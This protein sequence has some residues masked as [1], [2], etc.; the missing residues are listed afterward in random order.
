MT[1]GGTGTRF[2]L[3]HDMIARQVFAKASAEAQTRRKIERYVR[4]RHSRGALLTAEDLDDVRKH[5]EAIDLDGDKLAFIRRSEAAVRRARDIRRGLYALAGLGLVALAATAGGLLQSRKAAAYQAG[6]AASRQLSA[7]AGTAISDGRLDL[8][9][10]LAIEALA[11]SPDDVGARSALLQWHIERRVRGYF[12]APTATAAVLSVAFSPDGRHMAS[13]GLDHVVRLWNPASPRLDPKP[14]MHDGEVSS[15]AFSPDGTLLASAGKTGTVRLWSTAGQ[16]AP[17]DLGRHPGGEV[18]SVAFSPDRSRLASGGSDGAVRLWDLAR[19]GAPA[20][21]LTNACAA[22]KSK[23]RAVAWR[24]DSRLATGCE[25]GSVSLLDIA[26]PAP[27]VAR[28]QICHPDAGVHNG[29]VV[30]I[31]LSPDGTTL[32]AACDDGSVGLWDSRGDGEPRPIRLDGHDGTAWSVAFSPDGRKLATAGADHT[33][34]LWDV[35]SQRQDGNALQTTAQVLAV[36]FTPDGTAVASAWND[37]A[38][39]LWE[40]AEPLPLGHLLGNTGPVWSVAFSANGQTLASGGAVERPDAALSGTVRRWN[41]VTEQQILP[42]SRHAIEVYRVAFGPGDLLAAASRDTTIWRASDGAQVGG[43]IEANTVVLSAAFNPTG[44]LVAT[45][46]GNDVRLWSV[47]DGAPEG[48]LPGHQKKVTDIAF[49]PDGRLLASASEDRTV[50]LWAVAGRAAVENG[51]LEGHTDRV[52]GVA[53]SPDGRTLASASDDG[54]VRLWAVEGP[55]P[56]GDPLDHAAGVQSVVFSPDGRMLASA[57]DDGAVRLWNVASRTIIGLPLPGHR[58]SARSVAFSPD[59][60]ALAS[61]GLDGRV[62]LRDIDLDSWRTLACAVAGRNLSR[63]EWRQYVGTDPG[64]HPT[65]PTFAP[66]EEAPTS[67]RP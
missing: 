61:G 65:C 35:A 4:D 27:P 54:T 8:A 52:N 62:I 42:E 11:A 6:L 1:G 59:G 67:P 38:V 46:E 45:T 18:F 63:Q 21:P 56:I 53:F 43:A 19:P 64:Y 10:L 48:S 17:Q 47:S 25:D 22:D 44:N 5:L 7:A 32:A 34:R 12:R 58:G 9:A 29:W 50:R 2:E 15:V 16:P 13:A 31:A 60:K 3:S 36:A 49:S 39:V 55:T 37:G 14:L 41:V 23:V 57:S 26:R 33:V 66:A 40:V 51:T 28:L 24:R 30:S 20:V